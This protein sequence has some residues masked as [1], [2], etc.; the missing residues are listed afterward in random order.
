MKRYQE[1]SPIRRKLRKLWYVMVPVLWI[2]GKIR[3]EGVRDD[4]TMEYHSITSKQLWQLCIGTVQYRYMNWYYT[5]EEI[6]AH[7]NIKFDDKT[8]PPTS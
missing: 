7:L 6:Q 4:Q 3:G 2:W 5:H 1:C 8:K